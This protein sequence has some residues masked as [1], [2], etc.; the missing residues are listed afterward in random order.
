[1]KEYLKMDAQL[2]F[3]KAIGQH[4]QVLQTLVVVGGMA[5]DLLAS[6]CLRPQGGQQEEVG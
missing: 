5:D 3:L 4:A 6:N 1:M 2:Q